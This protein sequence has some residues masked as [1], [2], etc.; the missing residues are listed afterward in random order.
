MDPYVEEIVKQSVPKINPDIANGLAVKHM[1]DTVN[2]VN[3]VFNEVAKNFPPQLKYLGCEKCSPEEEF[4]YATAKK[5]SKRTFDIA[6]NDMFLMKFYFSLEGVPLK[7][8]RYAYLPFVSDNTPGGMYLNGTQYFVVPTLSDTTFSPSEKGV[9]I[10]LL[11]DKLNFERS[12]FHILVDGETT[13][14]QI[15]HSLIYHNSQRNKGGKPSVKANCAVAHYLFCKYGLK[16]VFEKYCGFTPVVGLDSEIDTEGFPPD[17]WTIF[18]SRKIKPPGYGKLKYLGENK[19]AMALPKDKIDRVALSLVG[20]F[21]YVIDHFPDQMR[22]EWVDEVQQWKLL[23]GTI[24]FGSNIHRG[25]IIEDIQDHFNSLDDYIDNIIQEKLKTDGYVC[26]DIYDLFVI[27]LNNIDNWARRAPSVINSMYGKELTILY[28]VLYEITAAIFKM[29]FKLKSSA[30]KGL[31]E[32]DVESIMNA[33]FKPRVVYRIT[34]GQGSVKSDSYSGDNK[35]FGVTTSLVPQKSSG[36]QSNSKERPSLRDSSKRLHVSVAEVGG[37]SNLPK[38]EASGRS[39]INPH[40]MV[41]SHNRVMQDPDKLELLDKVQ[42]MLNAT[43][44]Y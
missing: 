43:Y 13:T 41:D 21:Y 7:Q 20:G 32:R 16:G 19:I 12:P 29:Y 2:Y 36:S 4:N 25:R 35:I 40:L 27:V 34:R 14:I 3:S 39:C 5:N 11:R 22:P 15:A 23:L 8:P 31:K 10:R 33:Q 44:T 37:F 42:E 26:N 24:L 1:K 28:N 9:F 30:K 18:R 6:R 17:K 38:S